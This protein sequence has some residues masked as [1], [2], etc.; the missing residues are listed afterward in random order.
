VLGSR[1]TS[2]GV[3]LGFGILT[4]VGILIVVASF[5]LSGRPATAAPVGRS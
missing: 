4:V 3:S 2:A 5:G 1:A